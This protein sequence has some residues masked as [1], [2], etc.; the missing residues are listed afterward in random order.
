M[1]FLKKLFGMNKEPEPQGEEASA[2]E[3][4]VPAP[5]PEVDLEAADQPVDC[6]GIQ[7]NED[8]QLRLLREAIAPEIDDRI[9]SLLQEDQ[10]QQDPGRSP[11]D[12]AILYA[13]MAHFEPGRIMEVGAGWTTLAARRAKEARMLPGELISVDA[14]PR[15]DIGE[16]V[17]AHLASPVREVPVDDFRLM[18]EGEMV[19]VNST[20]V[21]TE[22]SD[23][24]YLIDEVLPALNSGVIVGYHGIHLPWNYPRQ[25]L[26]Q[27]HNEQEH[28]LR[29]L[30]EHPKTDILFAGRWMAENHAGEFDAA[31]PETLRR[32][33]PT[34]LWFRIG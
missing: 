19:L 25:A 26:E 16:L 7:W 3:G 31:M 33:N 24:Q 8:E 21:Y 23:A 30:R 14:N 22:G 15:L 27:H 34:C 18:L 17:D 6:T 10:F 1:S 32:Q 9:L 2:P 13:L 12:A 11:V 20:R 28:L 29:F 5:L 4:P